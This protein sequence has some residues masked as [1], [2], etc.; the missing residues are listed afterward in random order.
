MKKYNNG[1][2]KRRETNYQ[3]INKKCNEERCKEDQTI[4]KVKRREKKNT[5]DEINLI[6]KILKVRRLVTDTGLC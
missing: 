3:T 1:K 5:K 6:E 4:K 2:Q